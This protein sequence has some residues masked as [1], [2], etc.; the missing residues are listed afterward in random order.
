MKDIKVVAF[1]C[2][3]VLFDTVKANTG[4][5]NQILTHFGRPEMTPEQFAYCHMHTV[6]ETIAYLFGDE[7]QREAA[8]AYRKNMTYNA[9]IKDM[10]PEPYLKPLL[11]KLRPGY[12]T[13]IVTN[14]TDTMPLVLAEFD[15]ED[16]F[17][18]VIT[19]L[20]VFRP[21]PFADPLIKVLEYFNVGPREVIYVGDSELDEIAAKAAEIPFIAYNNPSL[22]ADFHITSLKEIEEQLTVDG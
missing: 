22:A 11:R 4:Y 7:N 10:E 1:D 3:G 9:F 17:D 16:D 8:E 14:R 12:K 13:A 19:A 20:D 6:N 18:L 21:K 2:D 15:L 5:Y